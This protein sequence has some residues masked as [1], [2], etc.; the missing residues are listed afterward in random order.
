MF[1]RRCVCVFMGVSVSISLWISQG[2]FV[3]KATWVFVFV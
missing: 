3:P 1:L 2:L